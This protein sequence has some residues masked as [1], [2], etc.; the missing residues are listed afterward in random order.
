MDVLLHAGHG[1]PALLWIG[2]AV[3][4]SLAAGV[5][6]G[7]YWIDTDRSTEVAIGDET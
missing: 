4:L 1:H 7:R 2:V 6:V 5:V 3:T